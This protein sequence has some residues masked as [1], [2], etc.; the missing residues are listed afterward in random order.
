DF[1]TTDMVLCLLCALSA[2]IAVTYFAGL[3]RGRAAAL[4]AGVDFYV[5]RRRWESRGNLWFWCALSLILILQFI[6]IGFVPFG[7]ESMPVFGLLP[8]GLV[9]YL[10][11][12]CII[13]LFKRGL[14]HSRK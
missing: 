8:A 13:F 14:G 11:D 4:C 10:V 2:F 7:G 3:G 12:E 6:V 1:G 5:G 9:I